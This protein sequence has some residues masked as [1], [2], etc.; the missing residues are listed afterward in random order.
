MH[1]SSVQVKCCQSQQ[2]FFLLKCKIGRKNVLITFSRRN[3]FTCSPN[4]Y[5]TREPSMCYLKMAHIKKK[6]EKNNVHGESVSWTKNNSWFNF[7]T[8]GKIITHTHN[9]DWMVDR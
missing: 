6:F 3:K 5:N 2:F 9:G 8:W 4:I 1:C 7:V